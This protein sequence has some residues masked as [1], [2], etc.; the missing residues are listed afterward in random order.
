MLAVAEAAVA[1]AALPVSA[2]VVVL[3]VAAPLPSAAANLISSP[4]HALLA[5]SI[6]AVIAI[7]LCFITLSV[8][9][10]IF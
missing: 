2:A 7:N 8:T 6:A 5:N 10:C 4:A 3:V 9:V 1:P